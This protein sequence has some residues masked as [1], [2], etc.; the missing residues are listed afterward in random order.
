MTQSPQDFVVDSPVGKYHGI[1]HVPTRFRFH[2]PPTVYSG[3]LK[4]AEVWDSTWY[5]RAARDYFNNMLAGRQPLWNSG[6]GV[7]GN[8]GQHL[9]NVR[10]IASKRIAQAGAQ[11]RLQ[12]ATDPDHALRHLSAYLGGR[13]QP[14]VNHP[15][16]AVLHGRF[17]G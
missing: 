4:S 15:L 2:V 11:Q 13:Q 9:G 12:I 14:I 16:D 1:T 7:L 5:G 10:D 8:I 6:Q 17:G 3:L